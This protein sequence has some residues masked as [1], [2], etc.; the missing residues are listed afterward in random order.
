MRV[1]ALQKRQHFRAR[2]T[3]GPR[4]TYVTLPSRGGYHRLRPIPF[5]RQRSRKTRF[6]RWHTT[7][8]PGPCASVPAG[9]RMA[10]DAVATPAGA[11]RNAT[12]TAA[13]KKAPRSADAQ[14]INFRTDL[15]AVC[16][17][18]Q[19]SRSSFLRSRPAVM[20]AT[21][22]GSRGVCVASVNHSCLP[23]FVGGKR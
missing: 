8:T 4:R 15:A 6:N 18:G 14:H 10:S 12:I 17:A 3:A 9:A 23:A 20:P 11:T 13:S 21:A 7:R 1:E 16:A 5:V 2:K 22:S 19:I